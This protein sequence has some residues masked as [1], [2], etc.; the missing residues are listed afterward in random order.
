MRPPRILGKSRKSLKFMNAAMQRRLSKSNPHAIVLGSN[1]A[2]KCKR[3]EDYSSEC[4]ANEEVTEK[5]VIMHINTII[6]MV[7]LS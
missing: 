2:E 4:S 5:Y 7:F 3:N 1:N 6:M